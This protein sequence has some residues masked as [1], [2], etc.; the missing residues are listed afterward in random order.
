MQCVD[1]YC[2]V[3]SFCMPLSNRP[4]HP[5]E[6]HLCF[7]P[8]VLQAQAAYAN[9]CLNV[10]DMANF[11]TD[12]ANSYA[13]G[14]NQWTA[15]G[16]NETNATLNHVFN[17]KRYKDGGGGVSARKLLSGHGR[18]LLAPTFMNWTY[19]M[20]PVRACRSI[21]ALSLSIYLSISVLPGLPF[22]V[23]VTWWGLGSEQHHGLPFFE[24]FHCGSVVPL[25]PPI[26]AVAV[27]LMMLITSVSMFS[28]WAVEQLSLC[29]CATCILI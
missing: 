23:S 17:L 6:P 15:S 18:K 28:L 7:K 16:K 11:N 1:H 9:F 25:N 13:K 4:D 3:F 8:R 12:P 14:I 19:M 10:T 27:C 26:P 22:F 2:W 5:S 21:L 24:G 20:T 29:G